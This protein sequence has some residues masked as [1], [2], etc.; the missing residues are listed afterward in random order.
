MSVSDFAA[1]AVVVAAAL[2]FA[3]VAVGVAAVRAFADR[4]P[5]SAAKVWPQ[6]PRVA[7]GVSMV[8]IG[9]TAGRGAA[10]SELS[11]QAIA[12]SA[13][14]A[15]LAEEP[16]LVR[17]ITA[18]LAGNPALAER[19]FRA[20]RL[21]APREPA[22]RY[23]L[24][25]QLLFT[26]RSGEGL[27]EIAT[28]AR[29]VPNG[30]SSLAPT[31]AGYARTPGAIPQ[32]RPLFR[33]E[34]QLAGA[35]LA[36]LARDAANA[37]IVL[38]LAD[39]KP[40]G[41]SA[42]PEWSRLLID[43]LVAGGQY[44][45][46]YRIWRT[47]AGARAPR[48]AIFDAGFRGSPAPPPF[49][50]TLA[51]GDVGIAEAAGDGALRIYFHG[52]ESGTLASQ[53]LLLDPGEYSLS[54]HV[55]VREAG[56]GALAWRVTCAPSGRQLLD[57]PI[58]NAG[59]GNIVQSTFTVPGSECGAQHLQLRGTAQDLGRPAEVIVSRLTLRRSGP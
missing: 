13:R 53:L 30:T 17:G 32:L 25:Q 31:L 26:G 29:L 41:E 12:G 24:A 7:I 8:D 55:S 34:P 27:R 38:S 37:D 47:V 44:A 10:P 18:Q 33:K 23:F 59:G 20:A 5:M 2:L 4:A 14:K 43:R 49:N 19:A 21:R 56:T 3:L 15:P 40:A 51:S 45:R 6:H 39:V 57:Q 50:W 28:L 9:R 35:V 16:F 22:P 11:L 1:V 52:R 54:M 48:A 42:A 46:A 58:D 36:L